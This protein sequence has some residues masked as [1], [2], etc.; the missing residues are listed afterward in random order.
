M[1]KTRKTHAIAL[2]FVHTPCA[3]SSQLVHRQNFSK[4]G[5]IFSTA[6]ICTFHIPC[7][8]IFCA[9]KCRRRLRAMRFVRRYRPDTPLGV[10]R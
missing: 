4:M 2:F 1:W 9:E 8:K 6:E 10:T 7:G 5:A 3:V